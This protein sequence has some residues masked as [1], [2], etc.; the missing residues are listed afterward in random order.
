MPF[1]CED[2]SVPCVVTH[3]PVS[4]R[5]FLRLMRLLL[6]LPLV[7]HVLFHRVRVRLVLRETRAGTGQGRDG[8]R[9]AEKDKQDTSCL[10]YTSRCV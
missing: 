7:L 8:N 6:F 9:L 10:L 5:P 3:L 4:L 2:A 1:S